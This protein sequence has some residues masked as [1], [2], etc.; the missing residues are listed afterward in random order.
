MVPFD[1]ALRDVSANRPVHHSPELSVL[2]RVA[3]HGAQ[4]LEIKSIERK[5]KWKDGVRVMFLCNCISLP[6]SKDG[7]AKGDVPRISMNTDQK[8]IPQDI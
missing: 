5:G 6:G 7:A 2:D 4:F 8:R 3:Q 1:E